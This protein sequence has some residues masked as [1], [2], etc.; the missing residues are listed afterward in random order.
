MDL[1][2][3]S[4]LRQGPRDAEPD[5]PAADDGDPD[6]RALAGHVDLGAESMGIGHE[7]LLGAGCWVLGARWWVGW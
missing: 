6:I 1:D 4:V 5:H 3:A 2:G 7:V